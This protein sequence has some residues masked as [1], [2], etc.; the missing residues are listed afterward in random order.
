[1]ISGERTA[2]RLEMKCPD[3]GECGPGKDQDHN[4]SEPGHG[5]DEDG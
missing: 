3:H 5:P 4:K 1:M 2:C